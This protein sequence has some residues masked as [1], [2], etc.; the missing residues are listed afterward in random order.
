MTVLWRKGRFWP[1]YE[2]RILAHRRT[3]DRLSYPDKHEVEMRSIDFDH[4]VEFDEVVIDHWLHLEQLSDRIWYLRLGVWLMYIRIDGDGRV[5]VS[6]S[7]DDTQ[8]GLADYCERV[9]KASWD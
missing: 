7:E 6:M 2:W 3:M 4:P 8:Q 9:R 5:E 1:G